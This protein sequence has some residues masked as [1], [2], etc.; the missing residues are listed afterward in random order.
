M[1]FVQWC[2]VFLAKVLELQE[3]SGAAH[4]L[5]VR[6][7]DLGPTLF[8]PAWI[9]RQRSTA[10]HQAYEDLKRLGLIEQD[11]R[12]P[13]Y[14]SIPRH[15]LEVA[16]NQ[17]GLW[18]QICGTN[19]AP[20]E[21]Q[22]LQALNRLGEQRQL[23]VAYLDMVPYEMLYAALGLIPVYE[24]TQEVERLVRNLHDFGFAQFSRESNTQALTARPTYAGL[25][26]EH[27]RGITVSSQAIDALVAEGETPTV[28]LK[29][30][31]ALDTASHKAELI[32][33]VIAL[34]NTKATG[35]RYLI[36]G[37]TD[38]GDYYEP[39]NPQARAERD[40]LLNALNEERLQS[41]VSM[42]TD[43]VLRIQYTKADYHRGPVGILQI[44]RDATE[45]PYVV[46]KTIGST[47]KTDKSARQ[48]RQ[49]QVFLRDGT[50]T[51]EARS[52][53]ID[54][55]RADA[56]RANQRRLCNETL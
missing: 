42:Y 30:Q 20:D 51:R 5:G 37:F 11:R 15:A 27:R 44:H 25:V 41:I 54:R 1:E 26:W 46:R 22:L 31:L 13:Q 8:G 21:T 17:K 2:G 50:I 7:N 28:D 3:C 49:G 4:T 23:D 39:E 14:F 16:R 33:D 24:A 48:V 29:R 9:S 53:E 32:K 35:P 6:Y 18:V 10:I 55:M 38:E 40:H 12:L 43:P 47:D 36:I 52:G 34:A 19:L 45:L 56:E